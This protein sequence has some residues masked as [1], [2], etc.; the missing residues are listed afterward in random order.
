MFKLLPETT[1]L[2]KRD[3][4]KKILMVKSTKDSIKSF[5]NMITHFESLKIGRLCD[6][7]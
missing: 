1:F 4:E 3:Q 5:E 6:F 2:L 7:Y